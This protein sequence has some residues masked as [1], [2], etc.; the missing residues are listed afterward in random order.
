MTFDW[1]HLQTFVAVAEEGS[2]SAAAR[3]LGGS[4]PTMGRGTSRPCKMRLV[5]ACSSAG[6]AAWN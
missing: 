2:L 5:C 4:Q 6:P 3:A 1:S